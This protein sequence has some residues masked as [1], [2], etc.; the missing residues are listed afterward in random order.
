M[1]IFPAI[2]ISGGN[3][4]RLYQGDYDKMT[5]YDA[6]PWKI[7]EKF[8]S[9]GA[10]HLHVVDLDGAKEGSTVNFPAI[11][12]IVSQTDM[13][14]EVGG[15]IRDEER[16]KAYADIGVSRVILGTVAVK[17]PNFVAEMASKYGD[18]IAVGV[19]AKDGFV[20]THGWTKVSDEPSVDF[21][22][23]MHDMGVSTIIYTDISKDG[24]ESGT[25][26]QIY[27]ELAKIKGLNIVASGGITF[28]DEIEVLSK[29][30]TYG[31]ILG[32]ALY[33]GKLDLAKAIE[34][35]RVM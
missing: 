17:N 20:A 23:R 33:T 28:Y 10:T 5:I 1:I 9:C 30:G 32:K 6:E 13:F 26:L 19:D 4:V 24:A 25:N 14:V 18:L 21:C 15:G 31:A 16:I 22:R 27:G 8:K 2:D 12:K 3:V 29:A 11:E 34:E 35:S 7:A